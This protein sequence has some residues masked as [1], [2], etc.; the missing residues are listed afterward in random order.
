MSEKSSRIGIIVPIG[1]VGIVLMFFMTL[2]TFLLDTFQAL[3]ITIGLTI[4][5]LSMYIKETLDF[6]IFPTLLLVTTLFRLALNIASTKLIL[7]KGLSFNGKLVRAFGDF[8]A[9]G[10]YIVGV[11]LFLIIVIIQFLVIIKGSE[12]VAEVAARFTLDAMPGKQMSIDADYNA[13]LITETEAK[14]KRQKIQR[15]ADFY[16]AMDGASKFVKGDAVAGIIITVIN[17]IGGLLIGVVTRG[18]PLVDAATTYTILTIGDGLSGQI[19]ALLIS[20]ATG[21]VVTRTTSEADFGTDLIKQFLQ[22]PGVLY[23][24][25]GAIFIIGLL[26]G[27]PKLSFFSLTIA[28]IVMATT[29]RNNVKKL[30]EEKEM[31]N[32][33]EEV[34]QNVNSAEEVK[35][36]LKVDQMELEMG[37]S[38]IPLVDE[39]QGG[40]LL[41][42]ITMIRKQIATELGIIIPPIRIRDNMQLNPNEYIL[43]IR[44]SEITK[45]ELMITNFLA[46]NPGGVEEEITGIPT[47]EPAFGLP[48]LWISEE[49]REK[50]EMLGYTVVD[51]TSVLA[52]HIT[53]TI[54]KYA[55]EILGRELV[56]EL[57]ENIKED[58][59]V[60]VEEVYPKSLDLG[61]IQT[62]LQ[63]LLSENVS[64]RNLPLI[65]EVLADASK[66]TK[67][68]EMLVEYVR[69]GLA[70]QLCNE[71]RNDEKQL[72]V[73]T[74]NPNIEEV[75]K[76]NIEESDLG[77]YINLPPDLNNKLILA[78]NEE[79]KRISGLGYQPIILVPPEIRKPLRRILER[80]LKHVVVLSYG[81]ITSEVELE[82]VGMVNVD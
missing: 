3:N 26:P 71:F 19:P 54:K 6:S 17:I 15:E 81:E 13:G 58:Y 16:G 35:E 10:N 31:E 30:E 41:E 34:T 24:V 14:E 27:M 33:E 79:V 74:L 22:E 48:A 5:L 28:L 53:E 45:G 2:P 25:A 9:G 43:K 36:L 68:I 40:D 39:T 46:M 59:A 64:I 18:E 62:I 80:D 8:V 23:I 51:P 82:A 55:P 73:L 60:V 50:A 42:R 37:Y 66:L 7:L 65:L 52:T 21:M 49:K 72:R 77:N 78:I 75:L 56:K 67:N 38:L 47:V 76:T 4:F 32:Q 63:S 1:L 20:L 70:R 57:I 69:S 12:R 44:G 11:I 61:E 29:M